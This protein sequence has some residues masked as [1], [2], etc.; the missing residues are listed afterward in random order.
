MPRLRIRNFSGGLV[1]NQSEFDLAENQYT[2]FEKVLNKKP[3]RLERPK[4]EQ[5]VS[6]NAVITDVQTEL[7]LY[8]TEKT[9]QNTDVSTKWWVF[10]NGTVLK[11][12]D[13]STGTGGSWIDLT[14]NWTGS[15]I[16]DFLVHNQILRVSDGSFTNDTKWYG[17]IKR[18]YV[19]NTDSSNYTTGYAFRPPP[20]N[21]LV[22]SWQLKNAK[23]RPPT[24]VRMDYAFDQSNEVNTPRKVGLYIHYPDGTSEVDEKLLDDVSND[25]FK[26][27]DK[28]TVTF[29]YDYVQES[30]LARD[31]QG[32]IGIESYESV[33]NN[34]ATCP[35]IQVVLYTGSS[36]ANLNERI[37]NINI[38]WQPE[39]D[40][41][42]YLVETLDIDR[43]FKESPLAELS[44]SL[45]SNENNNNGL[46][47][48]CM[49]VYTPTDHFAN[50]ASESG[51][52]LTLAIDKPTGFNANNLIFVA[53]GQTASQTSDVFPIIGKTCTR[54]GNIKSVS[55][56]T[57]REVSTGHSSTNI[58]MVNYLN[59]TNAFT[60]SGARA[61]AVNT[62]STKVATWY[63]P[64]DGLKLATYNSITGR[65][66]K[67]KLKELKWNTSTV[68]NNKGYYADVDTVDQSDQ[69]LREKNRVY[70]TDPFQLDVVLPSKY[71]DVG[72]NDG[73]EII[74]VC[75]YRGKIFVFKTRNTYVYNLR[76]QVEKVFIGVG[77]VHKHAV[78]E[79]PLGLVC[80]NKQG[81]FAITSNNS[82]ELSFNIKDTYQALTLDKPA[83]GYD[84]MDNEL[85]FVPDNDG[86]DLFVMNIDNGSWIKRELG[87]ATVAAAVNRSNFIINDNFRA[88]IT[89]AYTGESSILQQVRELNTG[90][91]TIGALI[92]T[93]S[94]RTKRF[95]FEMP[96]MQKRFSKITMIYKAS[97]AVTVKVYLDSAFDSS[98]SPDV[99]LTF[100][101]KSNLESVSKTFSSVGKTATLLIECSADNMEIDSIDMDYQLVGSNP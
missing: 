97:S 57:D 15:P 18:G 38:Y 48:P 49:S 20:M 8:R 47:I 5:T 56:A 77:A 63:L 33:P 62:S 2:A 29:V 73:D 7:L 68:V 34:G 69:T 58:T 81:I 92:S 40:V 39:G 93:A 88:Q 78:F 41:D 79:T 100:A 11:R 10:G 28:Y 98:G 32:N 70:F 90:D 96:D 46:W 83:I 65:A 67:T 3:G 85:F 94:V 22:N 52:T 66:A 45:V 36:L 74:K 101:S 14:T 17:H 27:H 91:L 1:T 50:V 99:T 64:Y 6:A 16:Y 23:L 54:I 55:I 95:D 59:E 24:V 60:I 12:Q 21:A 37:T 53:K 75:G 19:G 9:A 43:G 42:W 86:V 13:N 84:G 76:H 87:T 80:A 4:G 51:N 72:I 30:E 82:R 31:D 35:G 61:Y 89:Q 26:T 71:F 25:T 44:N